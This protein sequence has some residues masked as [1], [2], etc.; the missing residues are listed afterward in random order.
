MKV[1][2]NLKNYRRSPGKIL[3]TAKLLKGKPVADAVAQMENLRKKD[4]DVFIKL[5]KSAISN[6]ENNFNLD[7]NN[8]RIGE[9][10]V[11]KGSVL[12]RWRPRAYGRAAKILKR[13]CHLSL[14]LE[15]IKTEGKSRIKK[16]GGSEMA[17]SRKQKD[18]KKTAN[19]AEKKDTQNVEKFEKNREKKTPKG[20][21]SKKIFRRKSV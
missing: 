2:A 3:E 4:A 12:K 1:E 17:K 21:W 20:D 10:K 16:I 19:E 7:K 5:I 18:D 11:Q 15:E 8:L 14:I 13:S 9:V 6:A